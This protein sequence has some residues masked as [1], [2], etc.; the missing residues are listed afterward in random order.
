[1]SSERKVKVILYGELKQLY[2]DE[3]EITGS[4]PSEILNGLVRLSPVFH[5]KPGHAGYPVKVVGHESREALHMPFTGDVSELHVVPDMSGGKSGGFFQIVIGVL[6]IA[7]AFIQPE[8]AIGALTI[9]GFHGIL[10][11]IGLSLALG[12]L[13]QLISPAPKADTFGNDVADPEASKYLGASQNTVKI[14]TR[15]PLLY[16]EMQAFGQYL[17]FDVD[18]LD[19][20][21]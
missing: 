19:V 14:G 2:P 18:A 5:R 21:V 8:L 17:S 3:I 12:G 9:G 11:S 15:I 20:A 16:G 1:M 13:L 7:A 4:C 10:F 6:L